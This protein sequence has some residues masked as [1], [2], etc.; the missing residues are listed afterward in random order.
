M[1]KHLRKSKTPRRLPSRQKG[2]EEAEA[3]TVPGDPGV[4][5]LTPAVSCN[6]VGSSKPSLVTPNLSPGVD[7]IVPQSFVGERGYN[8]SWD[9]SNWMTTGQ[10]SQ[11]A[12][13]SIH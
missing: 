4:S 3:W 10:G 6:D 13:Y 5:N 2:G 12:D 11:E 8:G 1:D 9:S 7:G